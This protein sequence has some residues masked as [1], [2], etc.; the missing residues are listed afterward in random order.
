MPIAYCIVH[1]DCSLCQDDPVS[2]WAEESK[3]SPEQMTINIIRSDTQFGQ[4]YAAM[5]TLLL[6]TIWSPEDVTRLQLGL[7][8]ALSVY[9]NIPE[10]QFH[11]VTQRIESGN[12]VEKGGEVKW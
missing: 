5:V 9:L 7:S 2:I 4:P 10:S 6:P 3:H 11:I 1:S 12:V 8:R